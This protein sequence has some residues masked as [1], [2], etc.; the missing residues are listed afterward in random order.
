MKLALDQVLSEMRQPETISPGM[1]GFLVTCFR[2]QE[3][4]CIS[5]F[6]DFFAKV[7]P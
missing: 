6:Y 1:K 2:N 4:R 7:R 5:E 3:S